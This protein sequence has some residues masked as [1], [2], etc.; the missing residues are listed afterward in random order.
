MIR[1][2]CEFNSS[3]IIDDTFSCRGSQGEFKNTVV[4]RATI[5][6]QVP[7]SV[8]DADSIVDVINEWVQSKP[9]V[10]VDKV[11]L[12]LDPNCPAMLDSVTSDDC[13]AEAPPTN[14][15]N[16]PSSSSSSSSMSIGIIAGAVAGVII[17]LLVIIIIIAIVIRRKRKST[18][19]YYSKYKTF[20]CY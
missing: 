4:Y 16:Q 10:T 5:T 2:S 15:A 13:V 8:S 9:S 6:L 18:Y 19:R 17:I 14:Q 3:N 11:I 1:C 7:V 20:G 12:E